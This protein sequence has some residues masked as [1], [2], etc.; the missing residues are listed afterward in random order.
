VRHFGYWMKIIP[1]LGYSTQQN[2]HLKLMEQ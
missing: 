2:N 1:A